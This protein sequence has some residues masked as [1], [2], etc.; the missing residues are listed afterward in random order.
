MCY[1]DYWRGRIFG[2][3]SYIPIKIKFDKDKFNVMASGDLSSGD[4]LAFFFYTGRFKD[5]KAAIIRMAGYST[6]LNGK[7]KVGPV[8]EKRRQ[9]FTNGNVYKDSMVMPI[10]CTPQY[11]PPDAQKELMLH[12][13]IKTVRGMLFSD[14]KSEGKT[15]QYSEYTITIANFNVDYPYTYVLIEPTGN[16]LSITLHNVS[17]Y[18]SDEFERMGQYPWSEMH[19]T[20]DAITKKIREHGIVKNISRTP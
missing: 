12:S 3:G 11:D 4:G 7:G 8:F 9:E 16:I 19:D 20:T 15:N 1:D 18:D 17:D 5:G 10:D 13:I 2:P 14:M 6:D